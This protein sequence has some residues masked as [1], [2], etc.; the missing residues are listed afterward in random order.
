MGTAKDVVGNLW[1]DSTAVNI[2][3]LPALPPSSLFFAP[4]QIRTTE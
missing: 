1:A 2:S 4:R 3:E